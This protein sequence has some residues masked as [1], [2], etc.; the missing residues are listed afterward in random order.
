[1]KPVELHS[2]ILFQNLTNS[3]QYFEAPPTPTKVWHSEYFSGFVNLK[4]L[5]KHCLFSKQLK[6]HC[7]HSLFTGVGCCCRKPFSALYKSAR[8]SVTGAGFNKQNPTQPNP[9]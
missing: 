1:M 9:F 2:E 7:K 5:D 6:I 8:P 4:W 3:R